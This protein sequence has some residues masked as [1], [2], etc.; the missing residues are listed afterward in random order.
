M[1]M[2]RRTFFGALAA[3]PV[4]ATM[5][6]VANRRLVKVKWVRLTGPLVMG[7]LASSVE[8]DGRHYIKVRRRGESR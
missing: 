3:L 2:D 6:P 4:A 1:S 8:V 7:G 5:E